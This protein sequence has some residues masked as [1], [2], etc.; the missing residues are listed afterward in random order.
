MPPTIG[1]IILRCPG[2]APRPFHGLIKR[3][4]QIADMAQGSGWAGIG[5]I[6]GFRDRGS[7]L[8][9]SGMRYSIKHN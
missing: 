5:A 1:K 7:G 4:K 2:F 6:E 8:R 3:D 9:L